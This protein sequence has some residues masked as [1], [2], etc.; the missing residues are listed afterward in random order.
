MNGA[1]LKI[2]VC[3]MRHQQ[4]VDELVA[5]SVDYLG[6][7]FYPKSPR[8]IQSDQTKLNIQQPQ[9]VGVFVKESFE[10]IKAKVAE[11]DIDVVQ[12][13]GAESND[14]CQQV[15][16]LGVEIWRVC[17]VTDDYDFNELN[18]F[19]DADKFLF[20]TKTEKHGGSGKKFD[21]SLLD[22]IDQASPKPYFLA[23]GIGPRDAAEI[24]KLNL[25]NLVGLDL[26]SQFEI[27][28]GLKDVSTLKQFLNE[29]RK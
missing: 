17:A 8:S 2:K 7:I 3:G 14:I 24:K 22:K 4:N 13:H 26:N 12:L 20:D 1:S 19:P 21:W 23:G 25:K 10:T 9:K 29:L 18:N 11:H 27:E 15:K 16:I 6:N 28:P 5:L